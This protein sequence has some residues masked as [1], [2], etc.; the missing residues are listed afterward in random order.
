MVHIHQSHNQEADTTTDAETPTPASP[1]AKP[2]TPTTVP[3]AAV[4]WDSSATDAA[5]A[6]PPPAAPVVAEEDT[7]TAPMSLFEIEQARQRLASVA[8]QVAAANDAPDSGVEA[9]TE[10]LDATHQL[11]INQAPALIARRSSQG[12]AA[13]AVRDIGRVREMNQ[14]SVFAMITTLPREGTD[15]TV[16]LFIVADGMG[17][18]QGGELASRLAVRTIVHQ[19]LS[20]LVLPALDDNM[21]AALQPLM[22]SAVQVANQTIWEAA[23]SL[24]TD[25]GTTCTAALLV[26]HALYIAHVGDS[27]AY[28]FEPGG[29]RQLTS[30]HSTVGRLIQLGQLDPAE[31]REHPL[32]NQLYRTVGQQPQVMVDFVY[33]PIGVSSHLLLCS[34]GLWGLIDTPMLEQALK[35]SPWPQDTCNELIALANLAGGDDNI[36]AV[37][38]SLPL[39]ER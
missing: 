32:R 38:V 5:P 17:G 33:Q 13:M 22:I 10:P 24:G 9:S 4:W 26:G 23:Q 37:V 19:V 27:R 18:H 3:D 15:L 29:L 25:M 14:D 12:L 21:N 11:D 30:D 35:R 1:E 6:P 39:A 28:L 34:D 31:A 8:A 16:G 2:D 20:Q 36:S 7:P